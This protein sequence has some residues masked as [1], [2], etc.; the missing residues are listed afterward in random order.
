MSRMK[1]KIN[2]AFHYHHTLSKQKGLSIL[3][4]WNCTICKADLAA[5]SEIEQ[6][7]CKIQR[8]LG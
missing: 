5:C 7:I 8:F 4:T 3:F 1:K 6:E 2:K